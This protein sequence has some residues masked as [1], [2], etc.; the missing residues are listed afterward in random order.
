MSLAQRISEL[1]NPPPQSRQ[2][3][4]WTIYRFIS[5][6]LATIEIVLAAAIIANM[7]AKGGILNP[8]TAQ[9]I[10]QLAEDLDRFK[11]LPD[12]AEA[13]A[14]VL[15]IHRG[16]NALMSIIEKVIQPLLN[17]QRELGQAEGHAE[18]RTEGRTESNAA[19]RSWLERKAKT[20]SEGKT[21]DEPPPDARR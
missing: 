14:I 7:M 8:E 6:G 11:L 12:P 21:F 15:V 20:E 3:F 18:G 9:A 17:A 10:V 4:P 2:R 5:P 1:L 13:L 19:W 16:G